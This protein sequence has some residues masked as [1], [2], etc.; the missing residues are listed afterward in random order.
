MNLGIA[1][2]IH[3]WKNTNLPLSLLVKLGQP[4]LHLGLYA[5]VAYCFVAFANLM[6][7][8]A[9]S[10]GILWQRYETLNGALHSTI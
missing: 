8:G 7:L 10:L 3:L 2:A 1:G 9:E 5:P 6:K 4:S